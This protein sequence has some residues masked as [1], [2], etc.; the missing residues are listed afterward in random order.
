MDHME[1]G[2]KLSTVVQVCF[3]C[4][5]T[6]FPSVSETLFEPLMHFA[7]HALVTCCYPAASSDFSVAHAFFQDDSSSGSSRHTQGFN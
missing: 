5:V 4:S 7:V 1:K 3:V 2:T 6:S